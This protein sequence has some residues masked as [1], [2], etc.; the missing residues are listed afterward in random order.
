MRLTKERLFLM[1]MLFPFGVSA[2]EVTVERINELAEAA[3]FICQDGPA[4]QISILKRQA[5]LGALE[6]SEDELKRKEL[7]VRVSEY[8]PGE[9][10]RAIELEVVQKK[11]DGV[12]KKLNLIMALGGLD[13]VYT[14]ALLREIYNK[15]DEIAINS[16]SSDIS[17]V[18][19]AEAVNSNSIDV[20]GAVI[21]VL[22]LS[23]SESL[24]D[25]LASEA[26][27][28]SP[29][30]QRAKSILEERSNRSPKK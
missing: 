28:K 24:D 2:E 17:S 25:L 20:R 13:P 5:D 1:F 14:D 15:A 9:L 22:A 29:N 26:L 21:E 19:Q 10:S 11:S 8:D 6:K 4:Q 30:A 12:G 16:L 18:Y 7:S 3:E 23:G 27:S